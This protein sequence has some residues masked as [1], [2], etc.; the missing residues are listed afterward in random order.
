MKYILAVIFLGIFAAMSVAEYLHQN[1]GDGR[2]RKGGG[3]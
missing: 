2:P 3:K 1:H